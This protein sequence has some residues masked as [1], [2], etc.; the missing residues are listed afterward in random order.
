MLSRE[1]QKTAVA[2]KQAAV[3]Q[4]NQEPSC[5]SPAIVVRS[6]VESVLQ[7]STLCVPTIPL[8]S[9]YIIGSARTHPSPR[10]SR[11]THLHRIGNFGYEILISD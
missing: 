6:R 2:T 3:A 7:K 5:E 8:N 1:T 9:A 4:K 10:P 11:P